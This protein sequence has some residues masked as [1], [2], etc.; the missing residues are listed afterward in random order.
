MKIL[1]T[2]SS[3]TI[4]TRLFE[5]LLEN[6][7]EVIGAD[8]RHNKWHKHIDEKTKIIDLRKP[9]EFNA[10]PHDI[11]MIIHLA[12]NARVFDL[13]VEPD[14]ARDNF[15][16]TYN[17]ME[18]ARKN[19]IKKVI[20][21]S[22]REVY[23]NV[24]TSKPLKERMA[25]FTNCESPYTSTKIAGEALIKSYERCYGI[26]NIL[27]RFS[28]VYG[29]YDESDRV[30][31]LWIDLESKGEDIT[32]F[33]KEKVLDFTYIDDC[34]NGIILGIKQFDR[35]KNDI[36]NLAY[37]VGT[38][39]FDVAKAISF[40]VINVEP[41]RTGEVVHYVADITKAKNVLGYSPKINIIEGI[42]KSIEWYK[43][44]PVTIERRLT[45]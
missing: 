37:G 23:G 38:K 36:Y 35:V 8:I 7:Y 5:T 29:M 1:L 13:V 22:S 15:I 20:F 21:S 43:E 11:D 27:F 42:K 34:I 41:N 24:V 26:D 12:A 9:E 18:F 2:G 44:N 30:I 32:I 16:T 3:G 19:N 33:G 39:L 25:D 14:L 6:D 4:G 31:P 45:K 17:V 10:L 40:N 28:N